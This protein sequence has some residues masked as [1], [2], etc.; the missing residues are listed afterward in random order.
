MHEPCTLAMFTQEGRRFR[1]SHNINVSEVC[2]ARRLVGRLE[3]RESSYFL[4]L[5]PELKSEGVMNFT[6]LVMKLSC[7]ARASR[8]M[9]GSIR[10]DDLF[11]FSGMVYGKWRVI[12]N[13]YRGLTSAVVDRGLGNV[14][15][16][17][18]IAP[19]S[20]AKSV[21]PQTSGAVLQPIANTVPMEF[22]RSMGPALPPSCL[23]RNGR[24]VGSIQPHMR[25]KPTWK[26]RTGFIRPWA[27]MK[28]ATPRDVRS[29][30]VI[31][32]L[33]AYANAYD[34]G[35]EGRNILSDA[36]GDVVP[37]DFENAMPGNEPNAHTFYKCTSH[38]DLPHRRGVT[39]AV[40]MPAFLASANKRRF[41]SRG[42]LCR[43]VAGPLSE[44]LAILS[45]LC[46]E[47]GDCER[48]ERRTGEALRS[49][50][51]LRFLE[52]TDAADSSL[53]CAGSRCF[54]CER[55]YQ[56]V[57]AVLAKPISWNCLHHYNASSPLAFL[58]N[59]IARRMS[60]I[61]IAFL[62]LNQSCSNSPPS[63]VG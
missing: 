38:G 17:G 47:G 28:R 12:E 27:S 11:K 15:A 13:T 57:S 54:N 43:F 46:P 34:R 26:F 60:A 53:C 9:E 33:D 31:W 24:L 40:T 59:F 21:W 32:I 56:R 29:L 22:V 50:P 4:L 41:D 30:A 51:L 52:D 18:M 20:L 16:N 42:A 48:M 14:V 37:M 36:T 6:C 61:K 3:V 7:R 58:S 63:S 55:E 45:E 49:D 44:A 8:W 2:K 5:G 23:W 35:I 62:S 10:R 1:L 19:S 25:V 39:K